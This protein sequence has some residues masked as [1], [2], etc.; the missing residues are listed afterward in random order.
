LQGS[1]TTGVVSSVRDDPTGGGFKVLQTDASVNPGN[2]GGPLVNRQS[3]VIGIVTYKIRG[4]ENLNFAIPINYLRGLMDAATSSMSLEELR[5]KVSN[6]SD[7]FKSDDFP[8][9][10]KSLSSGTTKII[11]RD[12]DRLYVETAMNDQAKA[13]GC[14]ILSDLHKE[15][16]IFTGTTRE[17]CVCQYTKGLGVYARA[18]TNQYSVQSQIEITALAPN[19]IEGRTTVP[20]KGTK[21]D[22][23][24]GVYEKPPSEWAPFTWIPE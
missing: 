13:A 15:G 14:F 22:C 23:P 3:E 2:S 16:E 21:L 12:G 11:R 24:K 9:Q 7:V 10:W 20:P 19:R 17:S 4:G 1:V 18:Y 8:K 5:S 6:T